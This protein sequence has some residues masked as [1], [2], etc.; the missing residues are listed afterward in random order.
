MGLLAHQRQQLLIQPQGYTVLLPV[1]GRHLDL[2]IVSLQ[3]RIGR[4][5]QVCDQPLFHAA[6]L[7]KTLGLNAKPAQRRFSLVRR[8]LAGAGDPP[9][10]FN[11]QA[12]L[13]LLNK[14]NGLRRTG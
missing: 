13:A 9:Q 12:G 4:V 11:F 6:Q 10:L 5:K 2:P 14:Q 8:R 3:Q 7:L 1:G